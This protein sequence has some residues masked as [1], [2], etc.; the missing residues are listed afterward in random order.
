MTLS[1]HPAILRYLGVVLNPEPGKGAWIVSEYAEH[2]NLFEVLAMEHSS[3]AWEV[4]FR[5]IQDMAAGVHH[6]A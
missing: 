2:G 5:F 3:L 4:L 6:G 1:D